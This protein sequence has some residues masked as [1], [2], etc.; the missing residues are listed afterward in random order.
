M[1]PKSKLIKRNENATG[2]P[3]KSRKIN[4]E[5]MMMKSVTQSI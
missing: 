1:Y 4:A 5:R 3:K 2:T